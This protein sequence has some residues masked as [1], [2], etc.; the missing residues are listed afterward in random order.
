MSQIA[1]IRLD[2]W[3]WASEIISITY[4]WKVIDKPT[5]CN[6]IWIYKIGLKSPQTTSFSWYGNTQVHY[7][8][9]SCRK[10][11][12][13]PSSAKTGYHLYRIWPWQEISKYA[14]R[15]LFYAS[16]GA[17]KT[18]EIILNI[19]HVSSCRRNPALLPLSPVER[20]TYATSDLARR[21]EDLYSTGD[22]GL[23]IGV[24][25]GYR[26]PATPGFPFKPPISTFW[27]V[28]ELTYYKL[29]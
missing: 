3:R 23:S 21:S 9:G 28:S 6:D 16:N 29:L 24:F 5:H 18:L 15:V 27:E 11:L 2:M 14:I 12:W 7:L 4:T 20:C 10:L 22:P 13:K 8:G 19:F 17:W 25:Y 26:R 1:D